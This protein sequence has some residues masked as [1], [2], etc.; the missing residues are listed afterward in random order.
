M[1]RIQRPIV[2]TTSNPS[3]RASRPYLEFRLTSYYRFSCRLYRRSLTTSLFHNRSTRNRAEPTDI[4]ILLTKRGFKGE[5]NEL[6]RPHSF[7]P[8]H[9]AE[10]SLNLPPKM[11]GVPTDAFLELEKVFKVHRL[12]HPDT[13]EAQWKQ[14]PS[15][16]VATTYAD[17]PDS[18][19]EDVREDEGS[20]VEMHEGFGSP[21]TPS[22]PQQPSVNSQAFGLPPTPPT[23]NGSD[24]TQKRIHQT[25]PP[26]FA[27]GVRNALHAKKS[28][29][30]TP[31]QQETPLTPDPSPPGARN[32]LQPPRPPLAHIGS[33]RAESF[34]TAKESFGGNRSTLALGSFG[35]YE[36]CT[37][38][39]GNGTNQEID[40]DSHVRYFGSDVEELNWGTIPEG[41]E[42]P[43][44]RYTPKKPTTIQPQTGLSSNP[45]TVGSGSNQAFSSHNS[46]ADL[47]TTEISQEPASRQ[48]HSDGGQEGL[49]NTHSRSGAL[50]PRQSVSSQM[51]DYTAWTGTIQHFTPP[52][53]GNQSNDSNAFSAAPREQ[54]YSRT[55]SP[56]EYSRPRMLY[57]PEDQVPPPTAPETKPSG[58]R[59]SPRTLRH[60]G[61]HTVDGD[62][63]AMYKQIREAKSDRYDALSNANS[64]EAHVIPAP[65]ST[66]KLLRHTGKMPTLRQRA[67]ILKDTLFSPSRQYGE[68]PRLSDSPITTPLRPARETRRTLFGGS[69]KRVASS[70]P[71]SLDVHGASTRFKHHQ[72][73][74]GWQRG[75]ADRDLVTPSPVLSRHHPLK[76]YQRENRL[77]NNDSVKRTSLKRS[78]ENC[79]DGHYLTSS[80]HPFQ[81]LR[82]TSAEHRLENSSN[83]PRLSLDRPEKAHHDYS[84]SLQRPP[85]PC[86]PRRMDH[87]NPRF[88]LAT[89]TPASTSQMSAGTDMEVCEA[90]GISI[91]PHNNESLLVVQQ[92]P[93]GPRNDRSPPAENYLGI[94]DDA[95]QS[96]P[97]FAAVV[98]PASPPLGAGQE[99]HVDSPLRNPRAAPVPPVIKFI[100]PTPGDE[101][102][103]ELVV[104][105]APRKRQSPQRRMSLLQKARRYSDTYVQP[106]FGRT[107]STRSRR[108]SESAQQQD[109]Y[110]SPF[111]RPQRFW[112]DAG[113]DSDEYPD[114]EDHHIDEPLPRGGDTSQIAEESNRN[115]SRSW[116]PRSMSVRMPGFRGNGGFMAGNSL[117]IDRHGTNNRRPYVSLPAALVTGRSKGSNVDNNS[118]H[119]INTRSGSSEILTH[120]LRRKA[121]EEML[122]SM[123]S[124]R[125]FTGRN[126]RDF[127]IPLSNGMRIEYVGFT[128]FGTKLR[129][130]RR[131]RDTKAREKRQDELK[132]SI[133]TKTYHD[134]GV[135]NGN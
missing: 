108:T 63:D 105:D 41:Q 19:S 81:G 54:P 7:V 98:E 103:R 65:P 75:D 27:D 24:L 126:K 68:M 5:R 39:Q 18:E 4:H 77:E 91:Y 40:W 44:S 49:L 30:Q 47:D 109:N 93:M 23:T 100:P 129:Q 127:I 26:A 116:F 130:L 113:S 67:P 15:Q 84:S 78:N 90:Q 53:S 117:G 74:S 16:N 97:V 73:S 3:F 31:E 128:A 71:T 34:I 135:A 133:G 66:Q 106:L 61:T 10:E 122:R 50:T 20:D 69:S 134:N 102:D 29:L 72:R 123:S 132:R 36:G 96:P 32:R 121:S 120:S 48:A 46:E 35:S 107:I 11:P 64:V 56:R 114:D 21:S 6:H 88:L 25:P 22:R 52:H 125:S 92:A 95:L 42:V 111:W 1:S 51:Q 58:E 118:N 38:P 45:S 13:V 83:I 2:S 55:G 99:A 101:L 28:R 79:K 80:P 76:H 124:K 110:L 70:T 131:A 9:H 12:Q 59:S 115:R 82:R 87:A 119:P 8:S 86:S 37:T 85:S 89:N 14:R 33:S 60:T 57:R 62:H 94:S 17:I 43:P 112:D 104:D